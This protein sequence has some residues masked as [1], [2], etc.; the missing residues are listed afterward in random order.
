M[1][2]M[3]DDILSNQ[4]DVFGNIMKSFQQGFLNFAAGLLEMVPNIIPGSGALHDLAKNLRDQSNAMDN[5]IGPIGNFG[6]SSNN[7]YWIKYK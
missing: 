6:I 5:Q 4:G 2:K 1:D 3:L 7:K